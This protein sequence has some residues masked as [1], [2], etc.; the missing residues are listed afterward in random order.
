MSIN[1]R[2][3]GKVFED[4]AVMIEISSGQ[5]NTKIL[6]DCGEETLS[7]LRISTIKG[8]DILCFS[9]FHIDH[10][11]GFD[12]FVRHNFNRSIPPVRIFA[13][14]RGKE[15]ILNRL[16]GFDW[17]YS[18][19]SPGVWK[20]SEI[21]GTSLV[22]TE[23]TNSNGFSEYSGMSLRDI[24]NGVFFQNKDFTISSIALNH[25][26]E[27]RGYRIDEIDSINVDKQALKKM[28][29]PEGAW[30]NVIKNNAVLDTHII[31]VNSIQYETG[32]LRK[33]LLKIN[34]RDSVSVL[35]D[36]TYNENSL[37]EI[38]NFIKGSKAVYCESQ[39]LSEDED[40][41]E[42][43]FHLTSKKAAILAKQAEVKKLILF[44]ISRRYD[45]KKLK[46]FLIEARKVFEET[47]FPPSWKINL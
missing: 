13:P 39:Y 4:N 35:T 45:K 31:T 38:S 46:N 37:N 28:N 3:L 18:G 43:N 23:Y 16:R 15:I 19:D 12:Q 14:K 26:I 27:T 7:N 8:I 30:I 20:I 17:N 5:Q 34:K 10:I 32:F 22:T 41:A 11:S 9:H 36:F 47:Y 33:N 24:K 29:L 25:G 6:I 40:L 44:H 21:D 2:I 42:S 1:G